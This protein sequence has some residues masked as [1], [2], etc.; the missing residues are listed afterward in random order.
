MTDC[1]VRLGL[2]LGIIALVSALLY[3]FGNRPARAVE[4]GTFSTS[5]R[6]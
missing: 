3:Q 4:P 6:R 1:W 2:V 5:V